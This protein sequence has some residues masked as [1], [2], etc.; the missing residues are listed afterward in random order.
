MEGS[1]NS[2]SQQASSTARN[3]HSLHPA[4]CQRNF[5]LINVP[6]I[7]SLDKSMD[8]PSCFVEMQE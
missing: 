2:V 8:F 6:K 4:A 1:S 3:S 7:L 5:L